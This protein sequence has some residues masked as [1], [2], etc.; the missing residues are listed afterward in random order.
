MLLV[1]FDIVSMF[2]NIDHVKGIQTV[3]ITFD[4][5]EVRNHLQNIYRKLSIIK[6]L[7]IRL[8]NNNYKPIKIICYRQM[9][10]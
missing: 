7:E 5:R 10:H 3:K 8:H 1:S 4:N 6:A 9:T 2:L